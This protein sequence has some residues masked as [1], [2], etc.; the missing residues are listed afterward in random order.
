MAKVDW[1]PAWETGVERIDRQ[2]RELLDRANHL[3]AAILDPREA[4][5]DAE[6]ILFHLA[7]YTDFHFREEERAMTET[8]FPGLRLHRE[9][10][11]AMREKVAGMID[12]HAGDPSGLPADL[13]AYFYEWLANHIATFDQIMA[14]HLRAQKPA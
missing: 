11:D 7:Q 2:H 5:A 10:H 3:A 12:R 6:E 1:N 8:R 9:A 13:M 4:E 14:L